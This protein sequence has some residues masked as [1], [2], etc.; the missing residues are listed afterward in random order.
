MPDYYFVGT[1]QDKIRGLGRGQA[2]D[3][4]DGDGVHAARYANIRV[5]ESREGGGTA[6]TLS[7]VSPIPIPERPNVS[8]HAPFPGRGG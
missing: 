4:T 2:K 3:A 1:A 8:A 7:A 6:S 5:P